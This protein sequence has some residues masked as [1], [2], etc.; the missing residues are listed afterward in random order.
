MGYQIVSCVWA[1]SWNR[2]AGGVETCDFISISV[3]LYAKN[4]DEAIAIYIGI[5]DEFSSGFDF[6]SSIVFRSLV[7]PLPLQRR[8]V[9]L[10]LS[11]I[12]MWNKNG[13]DSHFGFRE[14]YDSDF[15][16][17]KRAPMQML[18]K[19][20]G[21]ALSGQSLRISHKKVASTSKTKQKKIRQR[22]DA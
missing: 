4:I 13:S 17:S 20:C 19:D 14:S 18:A 6:W 21:S 7:P 1:V 10:W 15:G 9:S 11:R 2:G 22:R 16:N 3:P 5:R 8:C 12:H